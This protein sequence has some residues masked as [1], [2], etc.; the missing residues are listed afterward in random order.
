MKASQ[1]QA[2]V[3]RLGE[4]ALRRVVRKKKPEEWELT[5]FLNEV[6]SR[7]TR[8]HKNANWARRVREQVEQSEPF[9]AALNLVRM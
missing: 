8:K 3:R 2:A 7:L 6:E 5:A 1:T 9:K 4:E